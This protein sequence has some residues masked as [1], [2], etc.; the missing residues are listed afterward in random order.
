MVS[1]DFLYNVNLR[2]LIR[3]N[4]PGIELP[5]LFCKLYIGATNKHL[6]RDT[7]VLV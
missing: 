7:K 2:F 1:R 3:L 4:L 5:F 6:K